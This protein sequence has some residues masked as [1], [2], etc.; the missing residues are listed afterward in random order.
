MKFMDTTQKF[1]CFLIGEGSLLIQCAEVLV[2]SGHIIY[3]LISSDPKVHRWAQEWDISHF[4]PE[5]GDIVAFLSHQSFDYLFSIVNPF[6]LPKKVLELP[7]FGA[8]NYHDAPL[9]KYAGN[10]ASAWAI[11]QGEREHGITWHEMID[12]VDAGKLLKQR[13]FAI[14]ENETVFSLNMKCY[15]AAISSF[16][17]LVDDLDDGNIVVKQQNLNERTFY[18]RYKRP[19]SGCIIHWN[20]TTFEICA[21]VR[22]LNFGPYVNPLG[23][24]KLAVEKNFVIISEIEG[25][26]SLSVALPGTITCIDH[27]FVRVA[28]ED[29]EVMLRKLMTIDGQ[30]LPLSDFVETFGLYKGYRFK[31]IDQEAASRITAYNASAC[32]HE[33]F[34]AKYLET[35]EKATLPYV[36]RDMS[37]IYAVQYET[38]SMPIPQAV[39]NHLKEGHHAW[40]VEDYLL[41]AF[42]TYLARLG[43]IWKF[44][45]GYRDAELKLELAGLEGIFEGHAYLHVNIES[46]QTFEEIFYSV[47]EQLKQTKKRKTYA[48]DI[49]SRFPNLSWEAK[50][51]GAYQPSIFVERVEALN[52]YQVPQD[53][54]LALVILEGGHKCLWVYDTH[55]LSMESIE[56]LQ[57]EFTTF[58]QGSVANFHRSVAYLPLL[59]EEERHQ[60][61][62]EWN[63]TQA[64]YPQEQCVQELFEARVQQTPDAVAVIYEGAHLTYHELNQRA[65]QLAYHLREQG[66][67]PE[68]LV[69]LCVKRSLEMIVGILG[70]LKA[71][72]AY[73]PLDPSSPPER[74]AFV[75]QDSQVAVLL[76]QKSL[77]D[78]LPASFPCVISLDADWHTISQ[79]SS[80]NPQSWGTSQRL[81]YVI[82]TS[83]STGHPKGVLIE[84]RSLTALCWSFIQRCTYTASDNVLQFVAFTFDPSIEQIFT[85]L[86]VGAKLVLC[87]EE[88]LS[89]TELL[90]KVKALQLTVLEFPTAY[91]H[92]VLQ[93]WARIPE[94]LVGLHLRLVIV[95]GE[96]LLPEVVHLWRQT[97]LR[98]VRFLNSYGPTEAT[99]A[100]TMYEVAHEQEQQDPISQLV[101]IGRPLANRTIYILDSVGSPVPIG[102][103]GE[104]YIGGVGVARG[105]LNRPSLTAERFIADPFT[106]ELGARLYRTGDIARYRRDGNIEFL[107]RG[108]DQVKIRG[109]RIELGEIEAVLN[110]HPAIYQSVV[111]TREDTPGDKYLVAYLVPHEGE[112]V[113]FDEVRSRISKLVPAYMVPS[114][115]VQLE[116]L[117]LTSHG[118]VDRRA[119]P[120]PDLFSRAAKEPFVAPRH[121]LHFQLVAIWE[122]ILNVYPIGIA[123]NFFNLGG[124]S[125]LVIRLL[126]RIEQVFH[127]KLQMNTIFMKP[128][129][130]MLAEV[131]Q[132]KVGDD[133]QLPVIAIQSG[134]A[135]Q[136]FF[137]LHGQWHGDA[138][139]CYPL[140]R[141]LGKEQPFYAIPPYQLSNVF[142]APT[143]EEIAISH[144]KAL[145]SVQ[146]NGPYMLGGWCNGALVAY[147]MAR[148]L[149][150]QGQ[151]VDSLILVNPSALTPPGR[152]MSVF[153][154]IIRI[155][156]LLHLSPVKQMNFFL[157]VHHL[158]WN[159]LHST[160]RESVEVVQ[161]KAAIQSKWAKWGKRSGKLLSHLEFLFPPIAALHSYPS[162]FAWIVANYTPLSQYPGKMTFYWHLDELFSREAWLQTI[163]ATESKEYFLPGTHE[164]FLTDHLSDVAEQM[165][166]CLNEANNLD[167]KEIR[168]EAVMP[169]ES[170]SATWDSTL[171]TDSCAL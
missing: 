43:D 58:L 38:V 124:H 139:Y 70:V 148:Q 133:L 88:M 48:R 35:L 87:G 105:Y 167:K 74:F 109:Y 112:S 89:P 132:K 81:A 108:D 153:K 157:R 122:D 138:F 80:A 171:L 54:E 135:K 101:P 150:T 163:E 164:T 140:A 106:E 7:C 60:L 170:L 64:D 137:F 26:N 123:D 36:Q 104:L 162:I 95:G 51:Q 1:S 8:I 131:L 39:M 103:A 16:S 3:G 168:N 57:H 33:V 100:A 97:P 17:E 50:L 128:T 86:I 85:T 21:F 41:V 46:H 55:A 4:D 18:P 126:E 158:V 145:Q 32:K 110:R 25:T 115:F 83:G 52:H 143:M 62:V 125:L 134:E 94:Q 30:P 11:M 141:A 63:A 90:Q 66:V 71:G 129:I 79:H 152:L 49:V 91:W 76:T 59:A 147:E 75:L 22:G 67:G 29:G 69:G 118:K 169:K 10:Y 142:V 127:Q 56:K 159:L 14:D 42:V 27:S 61:L 78:R 107:G 45:L 53:V 15:D 149:H 6:I 151:V 130:E 99:I 34:W 160:Y 37:C 144:V 68:V 31:E 102:V 98:S 166:L 77:L 24:P 12:I 156:K 93:E 136:P 114:A 20:R 155:G 28:T 13:F 73:V 2:N 84:H 111:V 40:S 117:P 146:P 121:M 47:G 44:D 161:L 154:L 116:T 92:Q 9:P 82:Y 165:L 5:T 120:V 19:S 72:G 65:N 23:M 96:R 113:K 119:L